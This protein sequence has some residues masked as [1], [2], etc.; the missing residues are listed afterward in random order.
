MAT[1]LGIWPI[2]LTNNNLFK[3]I[4][5]IV[6][7]F[8]YYYHLTYVFRCYYKLV[9]LFVAKPLDY[10]EILQN[11]CITLIYSV[12]RFR[13]RSFNTKEIKALFQQV[14][15][16]ETKFLECPDKEIEKIYLLGVKINKIYHILFFV[17]GWIV[18]ILY[19]IQPLLVDLPTVVINNETVV[20]KQ[21]PLS[22]WWP[23][24]TQQHFWLAYS[25]SI[26]DGTLGT[27]LVI[28]SDMLTF[29]LVV[30]AVSQL[31]ILSY[32]LS[33]FKNDKDFIELIRQYQEI[34]DYIEAFNK[35][36]KY[37][38]LFEFLQCSFQWAIIILQLLVMQINVTNVIFVGEFFVTMVIRIAIY[39]FN[40]NEIIFKSRKLSWDLWNTN[41]Y[42]KPPQVK[43]KLIIFMIRAQRPLRF[44]IG[45]FGMMSLETFVSVFEFRW[46]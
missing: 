35:A 19:F 30:F 5:K 12:C 2:L 40:G 4:Y 44:M 21:L 31:D 1:A 37:V 17:N 27:A 24:D 10:V 39:Y 15:D 45:P 29:S 42:E 38:M 13:L 36:M 14:I 23:F 20:L 6:G 41:W 26:F 28:S 32:R 46:F 7:S 18:T 33:Q 3:T 8:L 22:T 25:W 9:L 16:T 43:Q 11:L 34:I